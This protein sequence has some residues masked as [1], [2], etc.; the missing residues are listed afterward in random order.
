MTSL[1]YLALTTTNHNQ[2]QKWRI[3]SIKKVGR[4]GFIYLPTY[5][6]QK[7]DFKVEKRRN[8]D[9]TIGA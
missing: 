9:Y 2:N 8:W 5:N 4:D 3:Q 6:L 1:D 7:H